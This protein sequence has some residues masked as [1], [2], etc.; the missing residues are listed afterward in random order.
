MKHSIGMHILTRCFFSFFAG[1]GDMAMSN[2][3]GSNVCDML[4]LGVPWFIKTAFTNTSAPVEVNSRGLTY[5]TVSLNIS[6]IFLFFGSSLQWLET[7]QKA[8]SSLPIIIL[9][10]C[11]IISSIRTGNYWK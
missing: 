8:G 5:T 10:T 3:V 1:K 6:I 7:R 2:I 4:C 9:G 11:Y